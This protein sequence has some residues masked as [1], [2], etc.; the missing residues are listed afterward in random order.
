MDKTIAVLK[1]MVTNENLTGVY[2]NEAN[3]SL[4][5]LRAYKAK[6]DELKEDIQTIYK[7]L[8]S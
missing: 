2:H 1:M 5:E 7:K 8:R 4:A 6:V 3:Q